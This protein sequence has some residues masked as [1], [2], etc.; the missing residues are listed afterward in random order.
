LE[1]LPKV[2]RTL[3]VKNNDVSQEVESKA[4][5]Y[6]YQEAMERIEGQI[7]DSQ[8]L[9]KEVMSWI[10]CA[11]RPLSTL[12]LRH[13]LAVEIGESKFDENTLVTVKMFQGK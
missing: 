7:A 4:Y 1:K 5:D 13:A 3:K 2:N 12:E 10:T 8:K 6:A 9:A 11:T